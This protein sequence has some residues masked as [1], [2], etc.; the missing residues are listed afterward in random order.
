MTAEAV[1]GGGG[2]RGRGLRLRLWRRREAEDAQHGRRHPAA[3]PE[4]AVDRL[5][6]PQTALQVNVHRQVVDVLPK[7]RHDGVVGTDLWG[8]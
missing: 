2:G 3:V 7:E 4:L 8:I 1:G 6:Q 5:G